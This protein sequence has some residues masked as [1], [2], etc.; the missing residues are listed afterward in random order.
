MYLEFFRF[1]PHSAIDAR[2]PD[3]NCSDN[4]QTEALGTSRSNL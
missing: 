3:V 2:S 4:L 1:V